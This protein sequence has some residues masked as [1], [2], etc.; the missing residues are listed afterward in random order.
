MKGRYVTADRVAQLARTLSARDR[1]I[2]ETLDR[3]RVATTN[4]LAR[5]HFADLT[6]A[7]AARQ[8]PRTLRRLSSLRVVVCLE[9]QV[10]GIR[11]GSA[12]AVWALDTAGQ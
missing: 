12:A 5:L 8:T 7:S 2:V 1:D 4:Q 3:L 9:R 11:A 10:G 6:K